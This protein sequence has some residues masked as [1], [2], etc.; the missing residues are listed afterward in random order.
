MLSSS[1][2]RQDRSDKFYAY[3]RLQSLQEYVL[4]AQDVQRA[5][6]YRRATDWDFQVFTQGDD[7]PLESLAVTIPVATI[8]DAAPLGQE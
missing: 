5:E 2:E 8:Y 6:V 3:R 1:T 7:I 4:I